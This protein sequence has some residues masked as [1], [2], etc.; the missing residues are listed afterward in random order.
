MGWKM[1]WARQGS[2]SKSRW[3]PERD[4][5][6]GSEYIFP[7]SSSSLGVPETGGGNYGNE[8]KANG[9]E[10]AWKLFVET[11]EKV[12]IA[13]VFLLDDFISW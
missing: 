13:M 4:N 7:T 12:S 5:F 1:F 11:E 9:I 6:L 2:Q 10:S 8:R 3:K